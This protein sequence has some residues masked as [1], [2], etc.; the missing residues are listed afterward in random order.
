MPDFCKISKKITIILEVL[1]TLSPLFDGVS[2][3]LVDCPNL[4]QSPFNL[5]TVS[6][7]QL[8]YIVPDSISQDE[9]IKQIVSGKLVTSTNV[10][11]YYNH[12]FCQI[13]K[14]RNHHRDS[15]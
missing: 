1:S 10:K 14:N 6:F 4:S 3:E 9:A 15:M 8:I 7:G 13:N 5:P 12:N 11:N 2:C